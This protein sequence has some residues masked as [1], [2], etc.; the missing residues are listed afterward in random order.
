MFYPWCDLHTHTTRSDGRLSPIELVQKA[1]A[2]GIRVLSITDHN[3][4]EDLTDLRNQFPDMQL[5]QGAEVSALYNDSKGDEHE[6]HIV[7]LGFDPNNPEMKAMLARNQPDRRPYIEGMLD[8][9][10][11]NGIDLGTYDDIAK[12]FP[13]TNHIGR[14][15]LARCLFEDGYTSSIDQSFD[16]YLGA[17]GERRA[18]VKNPLKYSS[19]EEVVQTVIQAHGTPVL[20]HLLYYDLDNGNRTGGEE[21]ERLVRAFKE[22][23]DTYAGV[24]GMEVYYTRYGMY[25]RRYLLEIAQKYGLLISAGSDFHAQEKWESLDHRTSCSACSDLLNHLGIKVNYPIQPTQLAVVSG[26]SGVGKGTVCKVIEQRKTINGKQPKIIR[27]VTNR[28]PRSENENYTFISK[29]QFEELVSKHLLLEYNDSYAS[30]GYG[31]PVNEV[32]SAIEENRSIIL[33]IDRTGLIHL[34]TDGKINPNL[35]K[36]VFIV[37]DAVEVERRLRTRGTESRTKIR[38]RLETAIE[39]SYYLGLYDAVIVN[40]SVEVCADAV[41]AALEGHTVESD[42]DPEKFRADMEQLLS[43]Y[44]ETP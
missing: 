31:T 35:V 6:L 42:F 43:A 11:E 39:E 14:M 25:E 36:S 10:R 1:Y 19:L 4:T 3:T 8:K 32:K 33:E 5:I 29:E 21:K 23:V 20:A 2:A 34:L 37:A 30:C 38:S 17:H 44:R 12:R 26:Y 40:K 9:L 28:C 24:G 27:S 13:G 7:A 18:Y 16:L 15:A 22:L 41:V